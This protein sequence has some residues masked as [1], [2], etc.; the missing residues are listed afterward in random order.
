M[1][2][3][4]HVPTGRRR[5]KILELNGLSMSWFKDQEEAFE[6]AD[7][8]I[9]QNAKD[10]NFDIVAQTVDGF[11]LMTKYRYFHCA[12]KT[13]TDIV[14]AT[15]TATKTANPSAKQLQDQDK[16]PESFLEDTKKTDGATTVKAEL[17]DKE[18]PKPWQKEAEKARRPL[19]VLYIYITF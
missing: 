5:P 19:P 17:E 7:E 11:P 10:F 12:G 1:R 18:P 2:A 8:L 4:V 14:R 3:L 6:H 15:R 16:N 13:R 9:R